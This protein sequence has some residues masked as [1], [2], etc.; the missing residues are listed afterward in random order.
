VSPGKSWEGIASQLFFSLLA[1]WMV[2]GAQGSGATFL[3]VPPLSLPQQLL[4]SL[5]LT[6]AGVTGDLSESF[7]KRI[8]DVKDSGNFFPGHGGILDRFDGFLF[9]SIALS[10]FPL[11]FSY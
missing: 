8:V 11:L 9:S 10:I 2:L 3:G 7:L 5:L 1:T 4:S 6:V